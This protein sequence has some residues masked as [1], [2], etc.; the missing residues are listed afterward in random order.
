MSYRLHFNESLADG[1]PRVV[2]EQ[3]DR[4]IGEPTGDDTDL[5]EG[6]HRVRKRCK[7]I[8]GLLRLFRGSFP[9]PTRR[10]MPGFVTWCD[11]CPPRAMRRPCWRA[12]L[13]SRRGGFCRR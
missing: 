2:Q 4:A 1:M 3:L 7:K 10:R 8:R 11:S 13:A 12:W 6:V 9:L 5:P